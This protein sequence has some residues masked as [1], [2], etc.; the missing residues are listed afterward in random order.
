MERYTNNSGTF[1]YGDNLLVMQ[2]LL[3]GDEA[4]GL[5]SMRGKIDLIYIDPPFCCDADKKFGLPSWSK[6]T[7]STNRVDEIFPEI[8]KLGGIP[9]ANYLRCL[10]PRLYLMKELLS[11]QG[12][13]YV[14]IDWHVGHYVKILL[15]DIFGKNNILNEIIWCYKSGGV[16]DKTFSKKHD[17]ILFYKKGTNVIFNIQKEKSYMGLDYSTGNKNVKLYN[18]NDGLGPYTLVNVKDW[19]NTIGMLATSSKERVGYATQKPSELLERII[20]ASSN[21]GS[22]VADF[23]GGSGTTAS[24]AERLGRRWIMS[25]INPQSLTTVIKRLNLTKEDIPHG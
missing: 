3:N 21:E 10:Y 20:K 23:F 13:I 25:D 4:T 5:P 1:Y 9:I 12:S 16:G 24:V 15:D 18:D 2:A 6:N 14:H 8:C 11:E 19:W 7:Q 22:I 17:T